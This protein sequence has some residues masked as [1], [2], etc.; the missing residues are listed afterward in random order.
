MG[1][2]SPRPLTL[3]SGALIAFEKGDRF[4]L[5]LLEVVAAT[6][7]VVHIPSGVLAQ[8]WRNSARQAPLAAFLK[9]DHVTVPELTRP[10]ALQI[11]RLLATTGQSDVVDAQVALTGVVTNSTIVTTDFADIRA[12]APTAQIQAL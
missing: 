6:R 2:T 10:V 11:G 8:V 4:M 3:D 9:R 1:P 5:A 7:T 12:L